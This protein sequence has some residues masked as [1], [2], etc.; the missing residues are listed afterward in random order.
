MNKQKNKNGTNSNSTK[1]QSYAKRR[2]SRNTTYMKRKSPRKQPISPR[3]FINNHENEYKSDLSSLNN[4]NNIIK[5]SQTSPIKQSQTVNS[6]S[7]FSMNGLPPP[8]PQLDENF[9]DHNVNPEITENVVNIMV[10]NRR[11]A[12]SQ[13]SRNKNRTPKKYKNKKK[14]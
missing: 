13:I 5:R 14:K 1:P 8:P 11:K 6:N 2:Q 12:S 9:D 3:T 4:D 10:E 7:L